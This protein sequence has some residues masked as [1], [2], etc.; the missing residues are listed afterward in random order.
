[1]RL[2]FLAVFCFLLLSMSSV[3]QVRFA[4]FAGPQ[5]T[6]AHY[7]V[8]FEKI[9]QA[10]CFKSGV[11]GGVGAKIEFDNQLY[12]FP[13][14][15]YSLKGY[16]V[17]L[18]TP[19]FPPTEFAKYNNT[20]VHTIEVSPLFHIDFNKKP[21]HL[22]VRFGPAVDVAFKGRERFDTVSS[23]SGE[24]ARVDR[25]MVFSFG[26]YGRFSAQANLHFGYEAKN[27]FMI[28]AFYEH[29]FGSMNNAD[30]GPKIFH[31]IGGISFGWVFGKNPLVT[32]TSP[33][34]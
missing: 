30:R 34:R 9:K 20:T 11:M 6:S 7:T 23:T 3:G 18:K 17:Y 24:S 2:P 25:S 5:R 33:I 1:M 21:S 4:V 14:V 27:G 13:S 31:R 16:E 29:G 12:F 19:A 22:F 10:T 28:F 8:T 26:D 15:Y 32:D